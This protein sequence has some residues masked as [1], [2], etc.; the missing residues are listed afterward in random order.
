MKKI[1]LFCDLNLSINYLN[2]KQTSEL[3]TE[4]ISDGFNIIGLNK[5]LSLG[6][7]YFAPKFN[8]E[9][10]KNVLIL[11]RVTIL[12]KTIKDFKS[13]KNLRSKYKEV[14]LLTLNF[15]DSTLLEKFLERY[16]KYEDNII[17]LNISKFQFSTKILKLL[18][19]KNFAL[20]IN[21]KDLLYTENQKLSFINLFKV[22]DSHFKDLIFSSNA[23]IVF[24]R[25]AKWE[26]GEFLKGCLDRSKFYHSRLFLN[27][28]S[29][30]PVGFVKQAKLRS[31]GGVSF[32]KSN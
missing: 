4:T 8:S 32:V 24:E 31:E 9:N 27:C 21:Y 7:E 2:E 29:I 11:K 14:D 23:A 26:L 1:D 30:V 20:E 10:L 17:S 16:E 3:I 13:L 18:S 6:E 12:L 25:R 28:V 22:F 5:T 19:K 15:E